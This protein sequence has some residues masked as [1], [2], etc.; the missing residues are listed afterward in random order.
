MRQQEKEETHWIVG[1]HYQYYIC[2]LIFLL[3]ALLRQNY[4]K[5]KWFYMKHNDY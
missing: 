3:K 5:K 4:L 1:L 2:K